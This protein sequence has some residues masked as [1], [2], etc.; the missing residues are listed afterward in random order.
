[1]KYIVLK[2]LPAQG[3]TL[4]SGAEVDT[5]GWLHTANLVQLRYLRPVTEQSTPRRARGREVPTNAE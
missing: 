1:M 5:T 4:P 2:P 3:G